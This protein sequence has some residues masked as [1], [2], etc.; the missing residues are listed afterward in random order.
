[1]VKPAATPTVNP[2]ERTS[3]LDKTHKL[4]VGGKQARPDSGYSLALETANGLVRVARGNRKDIRNAVE[5]A[6]SA[7]VAWSGA[8][9]FNRSQVLYYFAENFEATK[10]QL[11]DS[12]TTMGASIQDAAKEFELSLDRI[13]HYAAMA[14]KF[15][16]ETH[17]APQRSL[18]YTRKEVIGPVAVVA[19]DE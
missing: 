16:A 18:I 8:T 5:A 9:A 6:D 10:S 15:E 7:F 19:P 13:L 14:D 4:Y 3:G 12:L 2:T 1:M 11:I 17:Q